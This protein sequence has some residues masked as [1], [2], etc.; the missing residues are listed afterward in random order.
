MAMNVDFVRPEETHPPF[1]SYFHAIRVRGA[2]SVIFCAEQMAADSEGNL[3]GA[4][5]F[6]AQGE[7]VISNLKCV[8]TEAGASLSD[9]AKMRWPRYRIPG[10]RPCG[11]GATLP[12]CR[13]AAAR[14]TAVLAETSSTRAAARAEWP[15]FTYPTIRS[16]RSRE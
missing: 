11:L 16:R 7:Q 4:G 13:S 1:S 3:V 5:E 2:G 8:L 12:W 14:R 15:S 9:V 10:A 6:A